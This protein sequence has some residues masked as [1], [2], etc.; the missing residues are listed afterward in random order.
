M[1]DG[2]PV[3]AE[4]S[5]ERREKPEGN[6]CIPRSRTIPDVKLELS[7]TL[8][9][10]RGLA[11]R[12]FENPFDTWP[13]SGQRRLAVDTP[14]TGPQGVP[15]FARGWPVRTTPLDILHRLTSKKTR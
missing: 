1:P 4:S 5:K 3:I 10:R 2:C 14:Q 7:P 13:F 9:H 15:I 12:S 6:S 11:D 8:G